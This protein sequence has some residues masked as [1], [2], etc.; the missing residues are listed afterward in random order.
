MNIQ[1]LNPADLN[2]ANQLKPEGWGDILDSLTF[3]SH[4]PFC[5]PMKVMIEDRIAGIGTSIVHGNSAWLAHIIVH[6]D[7]R[8]QGIGHFITQT[9][10][11][12]LHQQRIETIY[13]IATDLGEPVYRK[14]GFTTEA[15]YAFFKGVSLKSGRLNAPLSDSVFN[16]T[17][18]FKK[19]VLNLDREH[20]GEE[21]LKLLEPH[22]ENG[23][24]YLNGS[25]AEGFYLR[26][27]GEGMIIAS[28][29]EAGIDLLKLRFRTNEIAAFPVDNLSAVSFMQTHDFSSFKT[30]KRMRLGIKRKWNPEANFNRIGGNLG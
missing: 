7:F 21:R 12:R 29:Q 24:V 19:Q 28:T 9:L 6:P 3:Y 13:L 16:Y 10:V 22:L 8:K 14:L 2:A 20:S 4:S 18:E 27:L 25:V 11:D 23:L 30:A 17:V 15:E 5:F 26:T 1:P